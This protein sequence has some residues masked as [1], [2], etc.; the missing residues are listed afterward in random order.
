MAF[1]TD[2]KTALTK[3]DKSK[4]GQ[5]DEQIKPLCDL[6]NSSVDYYTTSSCS[7]VDAGK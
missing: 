6:I 5:I 2:K 1:E 7:G 4:K 3:I